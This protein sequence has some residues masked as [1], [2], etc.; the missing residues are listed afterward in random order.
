MNRYGKILSSLLVV[1]FLI[2]LGVNFISAM[3]FNPGDL[4]NITEVRCLEKN[5]TLCSNSRNCTI[6]V[7]ND[8]KDFLYINQTMNILANSFRGFNAGYGPNYTA[9]WSAVVDCANGGIEEF[10]IE[11]GEATTDWETSFIIG[12]IGLI[13]LYAFTGLYIFDK[14]YWL[15][16]SLLYFFSL[17]MVI[18]LM[19][20]TKIISVGD[21][22]D[23]I[24][25]VGYT[26]A[27]ISLSVMFLYLFVFFFIEM[28]KSMKEKKG[29]R[30][31]F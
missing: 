30:W 13:F 31:R 4:I 7:I 18:V 24:I 29:V 1:S 17:G 15:I 8:S 19:N 26:I 28:I 16:K 5:S 14:E 22:S 10:I 11:I 6:T 23:K 9:Q 12:L 20:S 27:I 3:Q 21:N 2:I 25:T